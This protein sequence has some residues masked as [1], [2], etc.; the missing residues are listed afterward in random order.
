MPPML[1]ENA[2][3]RRAG[4]AGVGQSGWARVSPALRAAR[5]P[6][7]FAPFGGHMA[8]GATGREA[9][10]LCIVAT[11]CQRP[12]CAAEIIRRFPTDSPAAGIVTAP[13]ASPRW[14]WRYGAHRVAA[15]LRIAQ[16]FHDVWPRG[17]VSDADDT[18][19]STLWGAIVCEIASR[20]AD[21]SVIL[22]LILMILR[23][24]LARCGRPR[25]IAPGRPR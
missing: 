3:R 7:S 17:V 24:G 6:T 5:P 23:R 12:R 4:C 14:G 2:S 11:F 20:G 18:S 9:S 15:W 25:S 1:C 10:F 22:G 8:R 19:Y 13:W 21:Y 16:L